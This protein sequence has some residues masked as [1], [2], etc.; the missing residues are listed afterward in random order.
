MVVDTNSKGEGDGDSIDVEKRR[1]IGTKMD[2]KIKHMKYMK[3]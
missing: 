2:L 3:R 1:R